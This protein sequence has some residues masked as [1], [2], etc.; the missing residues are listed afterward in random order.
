MRSALASW[1]PYRQQ[2]GLSG[3]IWGIM[4]ML[5]W[6]LRQA[7]GTAAAQG[8][9]TTGHAGP[10]NRLE[11]AQHSVCKLATTDDSMSHGFSISMA[12][13]VCPAA[14]W[15][16]V[17]PPHT[18]QHA[19]DYSIS[20]DACRTQMLGP[21]PVESLPC[22]CST[23]ISEPQV[24]RGLHLHLHRQLLPAGATSPMR[25]AVVS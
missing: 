18:R 13:A 20:H 16:L 5:S 23:A 15:A 1:S 8:F 4:Q 12:L 25:S 19:I 10:Y 14:Q 6:L 9:A 11:T 24:V 17:L 7:A 22:G 3:S 2:G 21:V